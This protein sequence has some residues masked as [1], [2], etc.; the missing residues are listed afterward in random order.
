MTWFFTYF[1]G[2][3]YTQCCFK[4]RLTTFIK[5]ILM[6]MMMIFWLVCPIS[7]KPGRQNAM[8]MFLVDTIQQKG[9]NDKP[10]RLARERLRWLSASA[11]FSTSVMLTR[12]RRPTTS[13]RISSI[14]PSRSLPPNNTPHTLTRT[15]NT[16]WYRV[17]NIQS[18]TDR[19]QL[20]ILHGIKQ[21]I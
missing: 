7:H 4:L 17:F 8:K 12:H 10:L 15:L 2:L 14:T 5:R 9:T 21:K 19:W 3:L 11:S 18:I 16:I 1:V 6:M 13:L 20:S